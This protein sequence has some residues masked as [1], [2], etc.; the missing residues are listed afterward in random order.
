MMDGETPSCRATACW[1]I[2]REVRPFSQ[3]PPEAYRQAV[4]Q[5]FAHPDDRAVI[6]RAFRS[7]L[8]GA[9]ATYE[10][11]MRAGGSSFVW[12]KLDVT[13]VMENGE[14][15]KMI[16]V[17]TDISAAREMTDTLKKQV[18]LD[19][20]T[21]L[22]NKK[23][24]VSAIRR[25]LAEVPEGR[26]ALLIIDID[27]F[28]AINDTHGHAAGDAVIQDMAGRLTACFRTSDVVS[29]FG[30]D[31]YMVLVRDL[32]GRE[33]LLD[34][35]EGLVS[36]AH[37]VCT[38]TNSVGVAL[39]PRDG[40]TFDSLFEQADRALYHA[41]AQRRAYAFAPVPLEI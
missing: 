36:C 39:F 34:R 26:H 22:C 18:R 24:A 25:I 11:R 6:D 12:C 2:L 7:I 3:L 28:K 30:G 5:Y 13:P 29:R 16:G 15:V 19:A 20:F 23:Y 14:A 27:G 9:P 32:P 4:S 35:L 31:E 40:E 33:W 8:S 21:G 37:P 41:K 17:I 10:A 1:E 38:Y